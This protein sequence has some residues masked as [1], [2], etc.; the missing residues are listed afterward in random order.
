[1][2]EAVAVFRRLGFQVT[3]RGYHT[4][5]SINHLVVLGSTY[6][7][8]LGVPDGNAAVRPELRDA[9]EGLSGL[10]F[11]SD[12]ADATHAAVVSRGAPV[13]PV[14]R[15]GRPV[16]VD[17]QARDAVF[18]TVRTVPG[19]S[20]AGRVY[21]C[22]HLTAELVWHGPWQRHDNGALD[23]VAISVRVNDPQRER[24]L[25]R[26]L[27]GEA[28]IADRGRDDGG[29]EVRT[30]P[31]RIVVARSAAAPAMTALA[32]RV[33]SLERVSQVL[34]ASGVDF[35]E[36]GDALTVAARDAFNVEMNFVERPCAG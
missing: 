19:S 26:A 1:M 3:P 7:E 27:L 16:I 10:V 32:I 33:R 13:Q 28:A 17:G 21:F 34:V 11:R 25:F 22:E 8:L 30:D 6:V 12:D 4:L 36:S 23:L 5:G 29:F 15:F 35:S 20:A 14:Q 18:R 31:V 24:A 9:P 2:D